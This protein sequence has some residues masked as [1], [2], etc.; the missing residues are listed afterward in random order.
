M[1]HS[2]DRS[3]AFLG[4]GEMGLPMANNL[5]EAGFTVRGFDPRP[6][7]GARLV[8]AGG[9]AARSPA[10]AARQAS[11]VIVMPFDGAQ[12]REA[13]FGASGA[14]ETLPSGGLVVIM[15]T[16]GTLAMHSLATEVSARGFALVDA[17]VTGGTHGATTGTLTVIAAGEASALDRA[18]PVFEP[19]SGAVYRVG[20]VPG[21]GQFVKLI[22][23]LL[24][25]VHLT[26]TAE[27]LA[28]GTAGGVDLQQL[29]DVLCHGFGRSDVFA[30]RAKAVLEGDLRTGGSVAIF[31]KDMALVLQAAGSLGVPAFTAATAQQFVELGAALGH[32]GE[33]DAALIQMLVD[34]ARRARA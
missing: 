20:S 31:Q 8:E 1:T 18:A 15:S 4:L 27:A 12:C 26:A 30:Q 3:V 22:N 7:R 16:I 9:L 2:P 13:L 17:P 32:A 24:V 25:G 23:Q 11:T 6:E 29:Y 14:L 28:L 19:M 34:L 33:D 5:V 10:D 21:A